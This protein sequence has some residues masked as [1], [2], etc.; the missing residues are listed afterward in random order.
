M[1]PSFDIL[2]QRLEVFI[3]RYYLNLLIRG[4]ILFG[5]GFITVFLLVSILELFGYFGTTVRLL[6]FYGF[7]VFNLTVLAAYVVRPLAGFLALGKR[8]SHQQAAKIL[9]NHFRGEINDK[10]TN[11][12]ELQG[13]LQN[14]Q[15]NLDLILASVEQKAQNALVI[16]FSSAIDLKSN[17]RL[18]PYLAAPFLVASISLIAKPGMLL[19]PAKRIANYN[20]FFEKPAPFN[21]LVKNHTL[22]AFKNQ[23]FTLNIST[24]GEVIP[25]QANVKLGRSFFNMNSHGKGEFSYLFRNL[26]ESFSFYVEAGGFTFGPYSLEVVEKPSIS[27]FSVTVTNPG[28]TNFGTNVFYNVGDLVVAEGAVVNWQ[29]Q[30]RGGGQGQFVVGNQRIEVQEIKPGLLRSVISVR[31]PFS[32]SVIM[33][34][35]KLLVGDSL[36]YFVQV[37]KDAWP[38]I[39]VEESKDTLLVSHI[40]YKVEIEDDYGFSKVEFRYRVFDNKESSVNGNASYNAL[41]VPITKGAL[42]QVFYHHFDLSRIGIKPGQSVETHFVVFDN[43][44]FNGPKASSSNKFFH[45]MATREELSALVKEKRESV[46]EQISSNI[47]TNKTAGQQLEKLRIDFL[48]NQK[49]GW[50]QQRAFQ[51]VLQRQEELSK[52]FEKIR[53][54]E[55]QNQKL[56]MQFHKENEHILRQR[57][58]L[59]KILD[60]IESNDFRDL[61]EKIQEL[62]KT[63]NKEMVFDILD[64]MEFQLENAQNQMDRALEFYKR[65]ELEYLLQESK[66][67]LDHAGQEQGLLIR[68]NQNAKAPLSDLKMKQEKINKDFDSAA[69]LLDEFREKNQELRR[70]LKIDDTRGLENQIEYGLNQSLKSLQGEDRSGAVPSQRSSQQSMEQLS[71]RL[72]AM[73]QS[74]FQN[75]QWEDAR[76]LRQILENLLKISFSQENLLLR[77]RGVNFQDPRYLDIIQGQRKVQEDM[78]MVEDSLISL[79]K[80]QPQIDMVITKELQ[81]IRSNLAGGMASLLDRQM[82]LGSA[83][84]QFVMTHINNLALLLNEVLQNIQMQMQGE[85]EGS[86]SKGAGAGLKIQDIGEMQ[87]RLNQI[88]EKLQQGHQ[89]NQGQAGKPGSIS[90]QLAR[91]AAEQEAIRNRMGELLKQLQDAGYD[92]K[93][94]QQVMGDMEQT[95]SDIVNRRITKQ[96]IS[97]QQQIITRLLEHEKALMHREMEERREGSTVK[98]LI[99]SNPELYF[100]YNKVKRD[101]RDILKG[102]SVRFKVFYQG[103]TE[104]YLNNLK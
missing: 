83:R 19:E 31:E 25:N 98:D 7:L 29:F 67:I 91:S 57:N 39:F 101:Q 84:Q 79:S 22:L 53:E 4:A 69:E 54:I 99:I 33:A 95:E 51:E 60:E 6:F 11:A 89:A 2:L 44:H 24:H 14:N 23:D 94:L 35:E 32:Y 49:I 3:K 75:Q 27:H 71:Q 76:A 65:L 88:L 68:E 41:E 48:Q 42:S 102:I 59:E 15:E 20:V 5:S 16:P 73:Q 18:I 50:E 82:G 56:Q 104:K 40:F 77:L 70:P 28:Y 103:I 9:G 85:G 80:R 74:M 30:T 58:E 66:S 26:R 45:Y 37:K 97:R 12:I 34:D 38:R 92:T 86:A 61:M 13:F 21:F 81:M 87:E 10:I 36:T 43:D 63:L 52:S 93:E 100:E 62:I 47:E 1:A 17:F 90:E 55:K 8:M 64:K 78:K 46:K 72:T 96:T